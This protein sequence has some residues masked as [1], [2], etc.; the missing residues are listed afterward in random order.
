MEDLTRDDPMPAN[1]LR[2]DHHMNPIAVD[3]QGHPLGRVTAT[4]HAEGDTLTDAF[5]E[6]LTRMPLNS[7]HALTEAMETVHR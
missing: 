2:L 3:A 4:V 6:M 5:A 1:G 7:Y